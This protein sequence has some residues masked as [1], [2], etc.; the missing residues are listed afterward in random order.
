MFHS[1]FDS[2]A[3]AVPVDIKSKTPTPPSI[4][5]TAYVTPSS[6]PPITDDEPTLSADDLAALKAALGTITPTANP[7]DTYGGDIETI[8]SDLEDDGIEKETD[9]LIDYVNSSDNVDGSIKDKLEAEKRY[10]N[11]KAIVDGM[12]AHILNAVSKK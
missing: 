4:N 6:T 3:P 9:A 12:A 8:E 2:K 7:I 1:I 5:I 10:A 11:T